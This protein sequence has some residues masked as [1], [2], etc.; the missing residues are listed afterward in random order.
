MA[1]IRET[2]PIVF[3]GQGA[4]R[5]H[6]KIYR[7]FAQ[8]WGAIKTLYE[9]CDE[10]IEKIGEIYQLYLSDYLQYLS[11]MIEKSEIEREEDKFQENLRKAKRGK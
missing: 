9:V 4:T 6:S 8:K 5:P 2:Y 1:S 3:G 11:F 7:D 10:K